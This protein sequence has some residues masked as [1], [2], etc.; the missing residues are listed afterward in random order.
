[1]SEERYKIQ[2]VCLPIQT[3]S[4]VHTFSKA[5]AYKT[6]EALRKIRNV[7]LSKR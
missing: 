3:T 2:I 7:T 5:E 4:K 6:T 1:M